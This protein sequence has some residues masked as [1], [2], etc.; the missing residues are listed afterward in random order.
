V[1]AKLISPLTYIH[2]ITVNSASVLL[3]A[4]CITLFS[5]YYCGFKRSKDE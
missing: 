2:S 1:E 4:T 5:Y 3:Y